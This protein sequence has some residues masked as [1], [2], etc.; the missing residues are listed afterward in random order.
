MVRLLTYANVDRDTN[1]ELEVLVASGC[2][3]TLL[4]VVCCLMLYGT[5]PDTRWL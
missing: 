5:V 2:A 1:F 4:S 3:R